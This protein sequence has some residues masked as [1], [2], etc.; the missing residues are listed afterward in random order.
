MTYAAG[1]VKSMVHYI[2]VQQEDKAKVC[3]VRVIPS[4]ECVPKLKL[5]VMYRTCGLMQQ[6]D[7]IRSLNQECMY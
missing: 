7:G 6:K 2:I 4:E 5:L 3:N 1:P